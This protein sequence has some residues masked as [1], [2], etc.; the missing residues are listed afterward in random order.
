MGIPGRRILLVEDDPKLEAQVLKT[1]QQLGFDI[2]A[3][4]QYDDVT[5]K[6]TEDPP[7]LV[8]VSLNLPRNYGYDVCEFIR[9]DARLSGIQI[10]ITSDRTSPAAIAHAEDAGANAFLRKPFTIEQLR[11]YVG[12]LLDPRRPSRPSVRRLRRVNNPP[13]TT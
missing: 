5:R 7:E 1:F 13:T 6:L 12:A 8:I 10:L 9:A 3:A 4:V 11:K 2:T